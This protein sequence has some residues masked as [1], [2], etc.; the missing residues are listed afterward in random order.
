MFNPNYL[1]LLFFFIRS[2]YDLVILESYLLPYLFEK[3][4]R[5]K[6]EKRGSKITLLKTNN[7]ICFRDIC[8]L[9]AP[10]T[11]LRSFG[12]M[13]GLEQA[14][15]HFPFGYL[16]S[17]DVLNE[18]NLPPDLS[19]WTNELTS[20]ITITQEIIDE[21]VNLFEQSKCATIGDYLKTY[22]KLDV[23]ILFE[24]TQAWRRTLKD[25]DVI[26]VDFI[27]CR[28]F[29]ISSL[30]NLARGRNLIKNRQIGNFFPNN[31]QIYRL[32][33]EGMRGLVQ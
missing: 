26:G 23:V 9:L 3:G 33:R 18:P 20:G 15:A 29:T 2:G 19:A 31:S 6:I 14:K 4:L 24:A 1:L 12:Q 21:A 30:S 8:K 25:K 10:N 17:V 32:L 11:N 5:P 22:L 27:E 28:K 7:G 16:T 13:C